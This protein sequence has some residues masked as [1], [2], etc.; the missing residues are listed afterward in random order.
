MPIDDL[1]TLRKS[2]I[3]D[4]ST[5]EAD[6]VALLDRLNLGQAGSLANAQRAKSHR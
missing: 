5:I 3:F 1:K 6:A 4:I 2:W